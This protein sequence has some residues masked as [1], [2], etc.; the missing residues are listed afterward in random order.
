MVHV[1]RNVVREELK[2]GKKLVK[3]NKSTRRRLDSRGIMGK[4]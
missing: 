4:V 2:K 3:P 1:E